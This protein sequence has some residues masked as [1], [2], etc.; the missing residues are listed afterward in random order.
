MMSQ[1]GPNPNYRL[2]FQAGILAATLL[3]FWLA[4]YMAEHTNIWPD[5]I[6]VAKEYISRSPWHNLRYYEIGSHLVYMFAAQLA[7]LIR[8]DPLLL[9][10]PSVA[11][12]TLNVPLLYIVGRRLIN[13]RLGLLA[14]LLL[15]LT[16]AHIDLAWRIRGYTLMLTFFLLGLY[17]LLRGLD[18]A[19][20]RWW[21]AAAMWLGLGVHTH[22]FTVFTLPPLA[23][24]VIL[25][26]WPGDTL[27]PRKAIGRQAILAAMLLGLIILAIPL[28]L[29]QS[30]NTVNDLSVVIS[31]NQDT[32]FPPLNLADPL[33][34]LRA[35]AN[36]AGYYSP[37]KLNGWPQVLVVGLAVAGA[38]AGCRRAKHGWIT[39]L[40]LLAI[41]LFPLFALT[42]LNTVFYG[43][44]FAFHRYFV[45][46]LPAYLLLVGLGLWTL[47]GWLSNRLTRST[48]SQPY[49][50]AGL[51]TLALLVMAAAT[52]ARIFEWNSQP[53]RPAQVSR[54]VALQYRPGDWVLCVP[55]EPARVP[56]GTRHF[57]A[58][59]MNLFPT[60]EPKT[61]MFDYLTQYNILSALLQPNYNCANRYVSAPADGSAPRMETA[62]TG[63]PDPQPVPGIWLVLWRNQ[64]PNP[65]APNLFETAA[66]PTRQIGPT[67]IIY[68]SP[69]A[70]L[71]ETLIE[72][73]KIAAN[74][75]DTPQRL[76]LNAISLANLY[77]AAGNL[78]QAASVLDAL[79]SQANLTIRNFDVPPIQY[80]VEANF[81]NQLLLL[82]YDL[83]TRRV[84]P[85]QDLPITLYW[86][87]LQPITQPYLEFNHLLD[88]RQQVHGGYDRLPR[89]EYNP[90]FWKPGEVVVDAYSVP[91]NS[92]APPGV[93]HLDLGVY[94][95]RG[96]QAVPLPLVQNGRP[97]DA[98]SVTIGPLKV[99]GPPPGAV[100]TPAQLAPQHPAQ[101]ELGQPPAIRLRGYDLTQSADALQLTLYWE[102]L[103]Q[104]PVDWNT[105][106]HLRNPAGQTVAQKDGPTG[107]GEYPTSLWDAGE[108]LADEVTL[109]VEALSGRHTLFIGLYDLQSGQRLPA[110]ANPANEVLLQE[111]VID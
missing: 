87:A 81:A 91:V 9:R 74:K 21:L 71:A 2:R 77:A 4:L 101:I 23:L 102:S 44:F 26:I 25:K 68:I 48:Q 100:L 108:L 56:D 75:A 54:T 66:P 70:S 78:E 62:C 29:Y 14:A 41:I 59:M 15:C 111:I 52:A 32:Q 8:W 89:E 3:L 53:R 30:Q 92:T 46:A 18:S 10:W 22:A 88:A 55:P 110:P 17:G 49:L 72:A 38:V 73:A 79:E 93:Y 69:Q 45:Y 80:R 37:L 85:G 60:L 50:R 47:G 6:Y 35:Y 95:P 98:N 96:E 28:L 65:A 105:F 7:A 13:R 31:E 76:Y 19:R 103:A 39:M 64:P 11:A 104:T 27:A 82:G 1:T 58:M 86:Q 57:C 5:E 97:I 24:L 43:K 67:E 99:G 61:F 63:Q 33:P 94:L 106:A 42:A 20:L 107:S 36:F 51:L 90:L 12:A 34:A 109:P 84:E 40:F 16:F 83:P